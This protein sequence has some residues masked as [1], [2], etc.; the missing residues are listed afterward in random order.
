MGDPAVAGLYV[1][2]GGF[3]IWPEGTNVSEASERTEQAVVQVMRKEFG[4]RSCLMLRLLLIPG[5][6]VALA[7]A[8]LA[9]IWSRWQF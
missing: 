1:D 9:L 2:R 7:M 6:I 8:V 3:H 4:S 5:A